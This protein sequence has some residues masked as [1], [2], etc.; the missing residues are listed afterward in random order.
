MVILPGLAI[1]GVAGNPTQSQNRTCR[2]RVGTT[3]SGLAL[4]DLLS[5]LIKVCSNDWVPDAPPPAVKVLITLG[6]LTVEVGDRLRVKVVAVSLRLVGL[7]ML[8]VATLD[9]TVTGVSTLETVCT[10][11]EP[12]VSSGSHVTCDTWKLVMVPSRIVVLL[13][14][15][16]VVNVGAYMGQAS[17]YFMTQW[18]FSNSNCVSSLISFTSHLTRLASMAQ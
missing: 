18:A 12:R 5:I 4:I 15:L 2:I 8:A 10:L 11:S 6:V 17:V 3:T 13:S 1:S 14:P 16:Q 9:S 7:A